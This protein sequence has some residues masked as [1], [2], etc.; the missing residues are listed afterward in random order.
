MNKAL[1]QK[2][3][4]IIMLL[5]AVLSGFGLASCG[6]EECL[7]AYSDWVVTKEASCGSFG[8]MQRTCSIC[9]Y[10]ETMPVAPNAKHNYGEVQTKDSTCTEKGYIYQVCIVCGDKEIVKELPLI[11]HVSGS[12]IT[13]ISATCES[14]G[15]KHK[16]CQICKTILEIETI[17]K[18]GHNYGEAQTIDSTCTEKGYRYQVCSV[19]GDKKVIEE[20][21]YAEHTSSDWIT[22][23]SAT[24]ESQG[25][26]HKE[27][28]ICK[29]ILEIKTIEKLG[30][31]YG[32]VQTKDSTC[33]ER[34]Y[35]YQECSVCGDKKVIEELPLAEHISSDWITDI[36]P[37][38]ES[39]GSKHKECQVCKVIIEIE[40]IAELGHNV[41]DWY[42]EKLPT[43]SDEGEK[44]GE[45]N[46]CNRKVYELIP[47]D[48]SAHVYSEW[49]ITFPTE[50]S[51]EY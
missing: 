36:S 8:E 47:I 13:D 39:Q 29:T 51:R 44:V 14:Q 42:T 48:D 22:D 21:P 18:L 2:L 24:C 27:C 37:T 32:E 5:I 40:T 38:C 41:L 20:L 45:C 26:K 12:W 43:C 10:A 3:I 6:E 17:E 4:V 9:N 19:C 25:S 50:T 31:N 23:I 15:S 46:A 34:G 49:S 30:H 7:H 1:R 35:T 11:A 28:Q 16:E 33:T